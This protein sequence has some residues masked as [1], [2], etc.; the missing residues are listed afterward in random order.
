MGPIPVPA[1]II[2]P[3]PPADTL[4]YEQS[5]QLMQDQDFRGRVKVA[6]L[7]YAGSIFDEQTN[8]PAHNTRLK[9]ANDT[10]NNPDMMA[11]KIQNPVVM[12]TQVQ[13][14]GSEI[15]DNA[16]QAATETVINK[17]M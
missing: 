3:I 8:V 17:A 14:A 16:L 9:W 7:K 15:T 5:S 4:S 11:M 2:V 13:S 1:N 10:I 6:C 12:D